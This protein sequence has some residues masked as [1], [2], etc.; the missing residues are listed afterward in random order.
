MVTV[1]VGPTL[2]A[3]IVNGAVGAETND[4]VRVVVGATVGEVVGATGVR[5]DT[6]PVGA[7]ARSVGF[8]S[9]VVGANA[10]VGAGAIGAKTGSGAGAV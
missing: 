7:G 1:I 5:L 2:G 9:D 6:G 4:A 8:A 10:V 3:V